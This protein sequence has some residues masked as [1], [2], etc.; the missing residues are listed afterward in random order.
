M[1]LVLGALVFSGTLVEGQ[2]SPLSSHVNKLSREFRCVYG[3][4]T[5]GCREFQSTANRLRII[6]WR[7]PQ[8]WKL[9]KSRNGY[10]TLFDKSGMKVTFFLTKRFVMSNGLLLFYAKKWPS[11]EAAETLAPYVIKYLVS[12]GRED[13]LVDEYVFSRVVE[14]LKGN[15]EA[16]ITPEMFAISLPYTP[17]TFTFDD[18]VP[19]ELAPDFLVEKLECSSYLRARFIV[20]QRIGLSVAHLMPRYFL[21]TSDASEPKTAFDN[22]QKR[23]IATQIF[24]AGIQL[25][26]EI[27]QL[28]IIHGDVNPGNL[29]LREYSREPDTILSEL[30]K[31]DSKS[32]TNP[33]SFF[34]LIDFGK[35]RFIPEIKTER[36]EET[37]GMN[38]S[39]LSP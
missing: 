14:R 18:E 25:L 7:V 16:S 21:P 5:E 31:A 37:K 26:Q 1:R 9:L 34:V 39:L 12:C 38:L 27:H 22:L 30:L 28:G 15:R 36:K 2:L 8:R 4:T 23:I 24:K 32:F 20:E 29:A 19:E 11:Q 35:A 3:Y 6:R 33:R 10:E 13:P 17:T